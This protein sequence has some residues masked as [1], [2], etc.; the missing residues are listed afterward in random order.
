[1]TKTDTNTLAP[2]DAQIDITAAQKG[3]QHGF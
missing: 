1:M 3:G 2:T